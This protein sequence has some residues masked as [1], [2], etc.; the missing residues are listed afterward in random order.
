MQ[1][2]Q[3]LRNG[4]CKQHHCKSTTLQS[5][6][7]FER[8]VSC[9]R[10]TYAGSH[11]CLSIKCNS[12]IKHPQNDTQACRTRRPLPRRLG[13]HISITL[14]SKAIINY[15][16]YA[17]NYQLWE[18]KSFILRISPLCVLVISPIWNCCLLFAI[19]WKHS[20]RAPIQLRSIYFTNLL[21]GTNV[22]TA[23]L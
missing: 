18:T 4:H 5:R 10:H 8:N 20:T 19:C 17:M 22:T 1:I 7:M 3:N 9:M 16:T 6:K 23:A 13:T 21:L 2:W 12:Q 14:T 11:A 15:H